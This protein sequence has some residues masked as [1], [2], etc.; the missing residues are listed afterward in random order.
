MT[1][2]QMKTSDDLAADALDEANAADASSLPSPT[3]PS[4]SLH[5][6]EGVGEA[7]TSL[8]NI[9][10]R[11]ASELDRIKEELKVERESL[12]NV[13]ENDSELAHA[14]EEAKAAT[15]QL[16]ERKSKLQT[17][18]QATQL[19]AKITELNEQKKE[20]EEALNNHLL[21]L[22]QITGTQTFDVSDGSQR[23]FK[24]RASLIGS[25]KNEEV[26]AAN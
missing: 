24:V 11:N 22:Y 1:D 18:P 7:L 17:S 6:N 19:K 3:Q 14:E 12:K 20:V 8:Q 15:I 4:S 16:K 13:F 10:E 2:D 26:G 25:K 21:N 5:P 23:E 9:I